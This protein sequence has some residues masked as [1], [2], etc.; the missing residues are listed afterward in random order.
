[1]ALSIKRVH[2]IHGLP[3]SKRALANAEFLAIVQR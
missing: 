1:M 3:G 2:G